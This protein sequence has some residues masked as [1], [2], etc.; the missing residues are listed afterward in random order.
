MRVVTILFIMVTYNVFALLIAGESSPEEGF[1]FP[2]FDVPEFNFESY[3]SEGSCGSF[4]VGECIEFLGRVM[5]NIG[6]AIRNIG[7][8]IIGTTELIF[9]LVTF[10]IELSVIILSTAAT[11]IDGAPWYVNLVLFTIP[12]TAGISII[13]YKMVRSGDDES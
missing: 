11:G 8:G 13:I 2:E 10:V 6:I 4:D 12:F 7:I 3:G 9:N 5:R 1:D